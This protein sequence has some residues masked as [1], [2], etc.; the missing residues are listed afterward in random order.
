MLNKNR[1]KQVY[2][3]IFL[4]LLNSYLFNKLFM[5]TSFMR[6]VSIRSWVRSLPSW[7][8]SREP[9]AFCS[10]GQGRGRTRAIPINR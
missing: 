7:R 9:S 6:L 4:V 8:G 2:E 5:S 1:L 3:R 10:L